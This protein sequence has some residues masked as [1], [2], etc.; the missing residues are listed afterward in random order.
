MDAVVGQHVT[1]ENSTQVAQQ[2][3]VAIAGLNLGK[4]LVGIKRS[5]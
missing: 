4:G 5:V 3:V 1:T 2:S